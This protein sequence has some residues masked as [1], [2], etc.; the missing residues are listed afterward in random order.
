M[1]LTL[2]AHAACAC[3]A[4][5]TTV[6]TDSPI[7][8]E[9]TVNKGDTMCVTTNSSGMALIINHAYG[10]LISIRSHLSRDTEQE[11]ISVTKPTDANL[12]AAVDFG[13]ARAGT[14]EFRAKE[15]TSISFAAAILPDF[16]RNGSIRVLSNRKSDQIDTTQNTCFFNGFSDSMTYTVGGTGII[17]VKD[18]NNSPV[19]YNLSGN[20]KEI[21]IQTGYI[22]Y[23]PTT[24]TA[25]MTVVY[26]Q[27][28]LPIDFTL[29]NVSVRTSYGVKLLYGTRVTNQPLAKGTF[30][31]ILVFS[32]IMVAALIVVAFS[33]TCFACNSKSVGHKPIIL[34]EH[35]GLVDEDGQSYVVQLDW[36]GEIVTTVAHLP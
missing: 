7:R 24:Q 33:F 1:L 16:C 32:L 34:D 30:L 9:L 35:P 18:G 4:D 20:R 11:D 6:I 36:R 12:L 27:E 2:I 19:I 26:D 15:D 23:E 8:R 3:K 29:V 14:I 17:T 5:L 21:E 28:D 22:M 25:S 10:T 13:S 31:M